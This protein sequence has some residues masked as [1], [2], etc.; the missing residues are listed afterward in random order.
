MSFHVT[1]RRPLNIL[2][3]LS[4]LLSAVCAPIAVAQPLGEPDDECQ[5]AWVPTFGGGLGFNYDA[6]VNATVVFDDGS[7]P[8]LYVAGDFRGSGGVRARNIAKWDGKLWTRLGS[9]MNNTVNALAVFDDGTGP[10]LYAGGAFTTAGEVA[11]KHIAKWDGSSWSPVGNE[12]LVP[13][14]AM[15]IFDDGAGPALYA[16]GGSLH[17]HIAEEGVTVNYISKWDGQSWSAVG[18][19]V[20]GTVLSMTIFDDGTGPTLVAGG[21]FGV[22]GGVSARSIASWNGVSWSPLGGGMIAHV[23]ALT[24]FDDGA[25]AALYAG[26]EIS[27]GFVAEGNI[28]TKSFARWDGKSWSTARLGIRSN[29]D[30]FTLADFDDGTG[31]A[32]YV[33]GVFSAAGG[34]PV[35]SIARWD[36]KTWSPLGSDNVTGI[37]RTLTL[38]DDGTG[39]ALYVGGSFS[40]NVGVFAAASGIARWD[41]KIWSSLQNGPDYSVYASTVFDDGTGPELYVGGEFTSAGGLPA[42]HIAKWDGEF[43]SSLGTNMV[44]NTVR[45]M[46]VFDDGSGPALYVGTSGSGGFVTE[47]G[48][49][50]N[51]YIAKWDGK[52]WSPLG[53]VIYNDVNALA[54]FDDGSGPALY[55]GGGF[56]SVSDGG[57]KLIN[58]AKWDGQNWSPLG[59]GLSDPVEAMTVFDD[60]S[61]PALYVGGSFSTPGDDGPSYGVAKWDGQQ[62]SPLG[63]GPGGIA[64]DFAVFDDGT[65]PALYAGGDISTAG[66]GSANGIAKWNGH[67]WAP[68]GSGIDFAVDALAVFDDGSSP[69]LYAG[70]NFSTAGGVLAHNIARWDGRS[71]SELGAG[72]PTSIVRTMTIFD[73]GEGP[74]LFVGGAIYSS[75]AGDQYLA[76]WKG[77]AEANPAD[78]SGDGVVNG[79]DLSLLLAD[80]GPCARGDACSADLNSD[81]VVDSMDLATLL[82]NWG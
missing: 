53:D 67:T 51:Y 22:A 17:A 73:D 16:G 18:G 28:V 58:I 62:W 23:Y 56:Y 63:N 13:I 29:A 79:A 7:G 20:D 35:K 11:V 74:A 36:G 1:V 82:A 42:F 10:A 41:G 32:L 34:V 39:P 47:G 65:G 43:W 46:A 31:P 76:K 40:T 37:V 19:G 45:S 78:F 14:F 6:Y 33:G 30:V 9:G 21:I 77:C 49:F 8:A 26:G 68:L 12:P 80:W 44:L 4:T 52:S 55:A 57:I 69:A 70:G 5:P 2:L 72:L 61:G 75:P 59:N 54:V 38:F 81:G 60:G 48:N 3:V 64:L 24:V 66:G 15:T 50:I 25:G 27:I 71:W